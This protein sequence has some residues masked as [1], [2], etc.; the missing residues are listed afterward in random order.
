MCRFLHR[1]GGCD[2][3]GSR[4]GKL[5]GLLIVLLISAGLSGCGTLK[6]QTATQ[7]LLL[8]DAVD[9]SVASIDFSP[10]SGKKIYLDVSYIHAVKGF[11]FVNANYIISSLRQQL[12]AADCLLQ[13]DQATAEYIVEARVGT[14][15]N[16]SHD[17][18]YGIPASSP[19]VEAASVVNRSLP[20]PTLPEVSLARR[21]DQTG[22]AKIFAFAYDRQTREPI[23]QSGIAQARSTSRDTWFLG[24]GPFQRG[25]I[26]EG[27]RFAGTQIAIPRL[28]VW[29]S[30]EKSGLLNSYGSARNF[31]LPQSDD[32]LGVRQDELQPAS[33]AEEPRL[34]PSPQSGLPADTDSSID[35]KTS[36]DKPPSK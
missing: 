7:Q 5:T 9:R 16:D 20:V 15:G 33:F 31:L 28:G 8:S 10:L 22:A 12:F 6:S 3:Y 32:S 27:M 2:D 19:L 21:S 18:I 24:A 26:H 23:W 34:L 29:R 30:P 11:G 25:T 13:D 14:L 35:S 4:L 1:S 17:L 36:K